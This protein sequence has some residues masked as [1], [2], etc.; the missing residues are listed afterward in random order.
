MTRD[1]RGG[2]NIRE[3][4]RYAAVGG[5]QNGLNLVV[6]AGAVW[7][8]LPYLLAAV[9]AAVVALCFSFLLNHLWTFPDVDSHVPTRAIRFAIIWVAVVLLTLLVLA[10][11]VDVAHLPRVGAQAIA[12]V[13]GA[14]LSYGAQRRWTFGAPR[15]TRDPGA[16]PVG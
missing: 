5:A 12:I 8:G 6:F 10:V 2:P 16:S 14:P 7:A 15:P 1:A 9:L 13:F 11:L 4:L 3:F